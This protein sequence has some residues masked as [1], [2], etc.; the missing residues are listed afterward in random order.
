MKLHF[1][2]TPNGSSTITAAPR[3]TRTTFSAAEMEMI[4]SKVISCKFWAFFCN[5]TYVTLKSQKGKKILKNRSTDLRKCGTPLDGLVPDASGNNRDPNNLSIGA[6]RSHIWVHFR[7]D[8]HIEGG[9]HTGHTPLGLI[10]MAECI[11]VYM[12]PKMRCISSCMPCLWN[13]ACAR[14]PEP[15]WMMWYHV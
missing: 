7:N 1:K 14:V 2:S 10:Y 8:V 11:N 3:T 4:K 6:F 12:A 9:S 13:T 15:L 5:K